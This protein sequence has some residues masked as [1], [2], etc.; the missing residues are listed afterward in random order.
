MS[1]KPSLSVKL[2]VGDIG[3]FVGLIHVSVVLECY[4]DCLGDAN[5]H[6][7]IRKLTPQNDRLKKALHQ[8]IP[9]HIYVIRTYGEG[10]PRTI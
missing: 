1:R 2:P 5:M 4:P 3:G 7:G 9:V 10:L 6:H 8:R